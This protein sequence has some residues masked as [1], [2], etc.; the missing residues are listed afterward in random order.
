MKFKA[1]LFL[2][3]V[4]LLNIETE[5]L[6]VLPIHILDK[7]LLAVITT[8]KLPL[9][10]VKLLLS[11]QKDDLPISEQ[12]VHRSVRS[13][14]KRLL[15][16]AGSL[17][18]LTITGVLT[19]PIAI[20]MQLDDPGP[21]FYSQIRCGVNGKHFRIW[22]F[23][24]MIVDAEKYQHLIKNEAQG[25]IFKNEND[26]RITKVGKFLRRTSLDE[27]PQFLNVLK[28]DMSL[29]GTRPPTPNEVQNYEIHHFQRLNVKPGLTGE[30]QA[31]GRSEVSD[32]DDIVRMDIAYQQKWSPLYDLNLIFK[33]IHAV[34]AQKGA[35]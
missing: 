29:V 9:S 35:C 33:T 23:R 21:V 22:K 4:N 5:G 17:V 32:F 24:S 31:N 14:T 15:D 10:Y 28:G 11:G 1:T 13:K 3:L 34:V 26:P 6:L 30:W 16:I 20:A 27:F 18:G 19:I 8:S 12:Q 2:L 7:R 25:Q